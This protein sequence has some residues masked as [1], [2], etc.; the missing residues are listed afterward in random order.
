[1]GRKLTIEKCLQESK[2]SMF[3]DIMANLVHLIS[4]PFRIKIE[5]NIMALFLLIF[6]KF[7]TILEP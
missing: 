4:T 5:N 6:Y 3:Y 1:M 7:T 2:S